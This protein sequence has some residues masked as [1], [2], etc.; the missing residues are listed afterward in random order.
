MG[1]QS[2]CISGLGILERPILDLSEEDWG[3]VAADWSTVAQDTTSW[4]FLEIPMEVVSES[5]YF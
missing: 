2:S 1:L 3:V 4:A 5:V